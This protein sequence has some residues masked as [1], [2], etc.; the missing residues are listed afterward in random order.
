MKKYAEMTQHALEVALKTATDAEKIQLKAELSL[1][2]AVKRAGGIDAYHAEQTAKK[3]E[4][5]RIAAEKA[6]IDA[7]K[8]SLKKEFGIKSSLVLEE[9]YQL[10]QR[11]YTGKV[12]GVFAQNKA[13]SINRIFE[14]K[15]ILNQMGLNFITGN[16]APRG[17]ACGWYAEIQPKQ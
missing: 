14:I 3:A 6:S 11:G 7:A 5:D 10:H 2:N 1:R 4:E 9:I 16:D 13:S 15:A 12:R 8:K 17:G